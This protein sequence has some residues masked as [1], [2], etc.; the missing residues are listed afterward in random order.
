MKVFEKKTRQIS[1]PKKQ[2]ICHCAPNTRSP[3]HSESK[4]LV[5]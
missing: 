4:L 2:E 1:Q 3:P 5:S